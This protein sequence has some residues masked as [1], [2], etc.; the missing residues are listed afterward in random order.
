VSLTVRRVVKVRPEGEEVLETAEQRRE[1]EMA[2]RRFL[3]S[4]SDNR[5][6]LA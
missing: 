6:D 5:P 3:H 1:R 2:T 4:I